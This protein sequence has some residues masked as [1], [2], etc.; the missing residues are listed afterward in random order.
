MVCVNCRFFERM[1]DE[2]DLDKGAC[3]RKFA[4]GHKRDLV[5]TKVQLRALLRASAFGDVK[6]MVP[7]VTCL[8]EI[9]R[10][11]E[12]VEECKAELDARGIVCTRSQT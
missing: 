11:K 8:D 2:P 6:I 10:V 12:L 9:R 5:Q 7:L 4:L 3:R 1:G